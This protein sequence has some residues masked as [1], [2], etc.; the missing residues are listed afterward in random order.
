MMKQN[1]KIN[2]K[3]GIILEWFWRQPLVLVVMPKQ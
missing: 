2:V 1:E 3:K